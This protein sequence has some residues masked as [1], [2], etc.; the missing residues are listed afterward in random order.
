MAALP[1]RLSRLLKNIPGPVFILDQLSKVQVNIGRINRNFALQAFRGGE[2][3]GLEQTLIH[4]QGLAGREW[5]RH[6]IYAPGLFTGYGVKTLP[7]IREAIEER[8]WQ[9][10][11]RN[12]TMVAS[13]LEAYSSRLDQAATAMKR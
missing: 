6:M 10:V 4:P 7:G 8:Q 5:Y 11:D 2:G 9:D 12:V 13:V 3:Q 1:P